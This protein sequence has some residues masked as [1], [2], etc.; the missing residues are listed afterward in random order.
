[1]LQGAGDAWPC[2][3]A[4]QHCLTNAE[5]EGLLARDSGRFGV[6][7]AVRAAAEMKWR[8]ARGDELSEAFEASVRRVLVEREWNHTSREVSAP[9]DEIIAI[10]IFTR[11]YYCVL[12]TYAYKLCLSHSLLRVQVGK[13]ATLLV[14]LF[15][16]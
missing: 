7:G 4:L 1:M 2:L 5:Q 3:M 9:R 14:P 16:S 10:I 12:C 11:K 6:S 8:L 15:R 13:T